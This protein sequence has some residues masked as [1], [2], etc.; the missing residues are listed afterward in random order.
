MRE[1]ATRAYPDMRLKE[2]DARIDKMKAKLG[3]QLSQWGL[4]MIT[5][6]SLA[7]AGAGSWGPGCEPFA[8]GAISLPNVASAVSRR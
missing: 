7:N 8:S 2:T 3:E 5:I 6:Q 4:Q 1:V